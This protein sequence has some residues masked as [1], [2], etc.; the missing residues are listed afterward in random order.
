M[1]PRRCPNNARDQLPF[2]E[3]GHRH[4]SHNLPCAHYSS[5]FIVHATLSTLCAASQH[6]ATKIQHYPPH[7]LAYKLNKP[8]QVN[9]GP[10]QAQDGMG[11]GQSVHVAVLFPIL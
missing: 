8:F 7:R 4:R 5:L 2:L 9:W 6:I 1:G 11:E 3:N 10:I